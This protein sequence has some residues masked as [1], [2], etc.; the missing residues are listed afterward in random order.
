M[1]KARRKSISWSSYLCKWN[2]IQI[3]MTGLHFRLSLCRLHYVEQGFGMLSFT[4]QII[5]STTIPPLCN[6]RAE[7]VG[8]MICGIN[9]GI[10]KGSCASGVV[11]DIPYTQGVYEQI[12]KSLIVY[13]NIITEHD[14]TKRLKLWFCFEA[15]SI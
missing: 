8:R 4:L 6:R 11:H 9:V 14:K 15:D 2:H 3:S 7:S 12:V 1:V 5:R 13:W 10:P